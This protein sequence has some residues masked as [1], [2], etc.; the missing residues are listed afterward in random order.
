MEWINVNSVEELKKICK[1]LSIA[2]KMI[3]VDIEKMYNGKESKDKNIS[4]VIKISSNSWKGL[5]DK[6]KA[7]REI[8]NYIDLT[9]INKNSNIYFKSK[10][11]E[12][13]FYL[14]ELDGKQRAEKLNITMKCYSYKVAAKEWRDSIA[15][16]IHP[17]K[18]KH[19]NA[20]EA[21]CKL[22]QLYEDMVSIEK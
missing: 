19:I 18:C 14:L 16:V 1:K 12:Y 3:K 17:D 11:A 9:Y 20:N 2:K 21:I 4:E 22:N 7:F 13:I 6:I 8:T 10:G 15:K 5:Y